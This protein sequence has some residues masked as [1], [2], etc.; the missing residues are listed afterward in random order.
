MRCFELRLRVV[1][2]VLT[3]SMLISLLFIP[4][5]TN[6]M[7]FDDSLNSQIGVMIHRFHSGL[8]EFSFKIVNSWF[9]SGRLMLGFFPIYAFFYLLEGNTLLIRFMDMVFV[10]ANIAAVIYLLR[11]SKVSWQTIGVFVLILVSLFQI[12]PIHDPIAS[13]AIFYKFLGLAITIS[14]IFLVKWRESGQTSYLVIS[15]L[16]TIISL[17]CYELNI[18]YFPIAVVTIL[19]SPHAKRLRNLLIVIS[20]FVLS[21]AAIYLIRYLSPHG[22]T[23]FGSLKAFPIVLLKQVVGCLPGSFYLIFGHVYNPFS[24]LI[25]AFLENKVAWLVTTFSLLCFYLLVRSSNIDESNHQVSKGLIAVALGFV[26]LPACVIAVAARYQKEI[27]WGLPYLP[28]YYQYFGLALLLALLIQQL[29]I[30]RY[31]LVLAL[32]MPFFAM[33]TTLNWISNIHTAAILDRVFKEPVHSFTQALREGLL[34]VVRDGD[35]V[36]INGQGGFI[37]GNL[38]Y[39]IVG[40]NVTVPGE[41]IAFFK[42]KPRKDAIHYHLHRQY[43]VSKANLWQLEVK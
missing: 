10:L 2:T 3:L 38:I 23:D 39:Q 9:I 7:W 25:L 27:A 30:K 19:I 26:F 13:Y 14:L 40:K 6:G 8:G 36:E 31:R 17:F 22:S 29:I 21:L 1:V 12:R 33:Y 18:I 41:M 37:S 5:I 34:D 32:L 20:L 28:V 43:D 16:V 4:Y 11:L 42:S 35:I 15:N 24:Q